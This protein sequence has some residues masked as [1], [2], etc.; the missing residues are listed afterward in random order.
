MVIDLNENSP[1][2]IQGES[3]EMMGSLKFLGVTISKQLTWSANTSLLVKR[4]QQRLFFLRELK[5]A[6]LPQKLLVNFYRNTIE[7]I[8]TN[9]TTV[10]YDGYTA[11]EKKDWNRVVK[12]AQ[13]N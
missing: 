9:C 13:G 7:S 4:A 12:A 2:H 5:Q 10:R 3:A 6:E 1:L 8:L 11:A